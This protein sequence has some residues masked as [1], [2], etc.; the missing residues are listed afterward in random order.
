MTP[1]TL[2]RPASLANKASKDLLAQWASL[3]PLALRVY[4]AKTDRPG[5]LAI[6]E[7]LD[8]LEAPVSLDLLV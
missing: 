8:I 4:L 5:H 6:E 3:D 7:N 2:D 1:V